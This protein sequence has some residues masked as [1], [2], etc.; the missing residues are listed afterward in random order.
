MVMTAEKSELPFPTTTAH[1]ARL[2][3]YQPTLRPRDITREV[4][5]SW[6][7][8]KITG[9]IGQVHASVMEAIFY[10]N[11]AVRHLDDGRVRI[12]VDPYRVRTATYGGEQ[13]SHQQLWKMITDLMRVI[14]EMEVPRHEI[15]VLGHVLDS[16]EESPQRRH[17]PAGMNQGRDRALWRITV[18]ATYIQLMGE[19]LALNYPPA[20]IAKLE[21]GV[22][23]AVVR[24]IKTHKNEPPGGWHVDYL[25]AAVGVDGGQCMRDARR[26][27][28]SDGTR[29]GLMKFGL[30]LEGGRVR[31][32]D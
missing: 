29:A 12:L 18:A 19:D 3:I 15:K 17:S 9:C 4:R 10:N 28:N 26:A 8:A 14:I 11:E 22:A 30:S 16:V 23:R 31:Q 1:Q 5:T 24:F 13:G 7:S 25:L 20:P 2:Q 6:G 27:L 32:V 21:S